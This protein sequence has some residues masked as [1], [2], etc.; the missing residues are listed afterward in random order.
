MSGAV[1]Y[2][3]IAK[4]PVAGRVKTRLCPP[5][6]PEQAASIAEASLADTLAAVGAA[7]V[8]D[9]SRQVIAL[10]GAPGPWLPSDFEVI[11]QAGNGL[12][13]RLTAA[14][15]HC[16]ATA[17]DSPVVL[18]GMDTPQLTPTHLHEAVALLEH[19]DAVL[20]PA[21]D[22]GY[23]LIAL[24]HL[25]DDAITGVPMSAPDTFE[26]Q[27]ERLVACGY[28]VAVTRSLVDV[29]DVADALDVAR[30]TQGSRFAAAV[31]DALARQPSTADEPGTTVGIDVVLPVLDEV[32]AIGWVLDRMPAGFHPIVVDNGSTDGSAALARSLGAEVVTEAVPGFGAACWAGLRAA[33]SDVVCFMDCDAS[34]DPADLPAVAGPVT[35]GDA[36]LVLGARHAE[37]GAWPPHARLANRYLA[38]RLR[39]RFGW[40]VTDLGPMRAAH[41][42][43]LLELGLQDR[44]SGWPLEMA[45]R[46]GNAGWRVREVP[47]PYRRRAGS[48]KVT[49]TVAGTV[50]AVGDMHRQLRALA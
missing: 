20:G 17:P 22:G 38:R 1:Q 35:S 25:T 8:A 7:A 28:D 50:R 41:R 6:T 34:L 24:R 3:V 9:G 26:R 16:L 18:V 4:E 30:L 45:L 37:P 15:G 13:D 32:D 29:D 5:C 19:H 46:A 11:A 44:R 39:R 23:W 12:D 40:D 48:S 36:D 21:P 14:I 10:D 31:E 27:H 2:V 47:V 33:T 49:G 42:A 43:D